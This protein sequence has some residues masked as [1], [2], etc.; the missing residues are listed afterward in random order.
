M[1]LELGETAR[2][3]VQAQLRQHVTGGDGL[4]EHEVDLRHDTRS[5]EREVH[6]ALGTQISDSIQGWLPIEG[7]RL[8]GRNHLRRFGR[9][10][11]CR[12]RRLVAG[13]DGQ[14]G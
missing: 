7:V 6:S 12:E 3:V 8:D 11:G 4:T 14:D 1:C 10:I 2:L 5:L 9:R 13:N